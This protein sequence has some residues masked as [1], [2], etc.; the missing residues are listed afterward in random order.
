MFIALGFVLLIKGANVLVDGSSSLAKRYG[1]SDI[2]IGLTIVAMGTSAPE[3]VVSVIAAI[4]GNSGIAIG[5]VMG[6][7][8]ANICLVMGGAGII[9]PM[10]IR[11]ETVKQEIPFCFITAVLLLIV[12]LFF[13]NPFLVSRIE[14]IVLLASLGVYIFFMMRSAKKSSIGPIKTE[15]LDPAAA[16]IM[17]AG[18]LL[19]LMLGGNLIVKNAVA[20]AEKLNVSQEMIG[21]TI[22]ALGTSLPELATAIAAVLKN[23]PDIAVGNVVGSNIINTGLVLGTA[24]VINP[25]TSS[26][27]FLAD[28]LILV[29]ASFAIFLFMFTGKKNKLDRWEAVILLLGYFGYMAYVIGRG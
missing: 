4:K 21:L 28:S 20:I 18:G 23:K 13:N 14:A 3:L 12:L 11:K 2:V 6:S 24:A 27:E 17:I 15:S 9:M 7:N 22:V 16:V 1:I 5:N 29:A 25:I 26:K 8:I 19:G 10:V